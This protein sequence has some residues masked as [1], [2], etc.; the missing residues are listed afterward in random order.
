M[1]RRRHRR[2]TAEAELN[3][4][5]FLNLMIVLVP[6][7]LLSMV[8]TQTRILELSFPQAG[9]RLDEMVENKQELALYVVIRDGS[10][11]VGDRNGGV[12]QRFEPKAEGEP[13]FAGLRELLK[14]VKERFPETRDIRLL[15]GSETDYQTLVTTMDTVRGYPEFVAT[16]VVTAELFPEIALGDA[17][18][19]AGEEAGS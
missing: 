15:A 1:R 7:L 12:L 6:V 11:E 8:F 4:T 19:P 5:P 10:L 3:I 18:A 9:E 16:D 14:G 2:Q 17:P 13:D